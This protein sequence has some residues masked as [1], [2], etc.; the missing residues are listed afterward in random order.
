[1]LA[2]FANVLIVLS[3]LQT[4]PAGWEIF[5]KTRFHWEFSE[6]LE[7]EVQMPYFDSKIKTMDGS[8][9]ELTG[10]YLPLKLEGNRIFLSKMPYA[11]CFFCGGDA[12]PESIVEV[13]FESVQPPFRMDDLLTI[14]G[15]LVLNKDDLDHMVFILEDA[16]LIKR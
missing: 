4:G 10:F 8:K 5:E 7:L 3:T 6:E 12:G 2:L 16:K 14:Q 1:M 13:A 9:V 15:T 11:A